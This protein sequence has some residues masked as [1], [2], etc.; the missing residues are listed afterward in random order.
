MYLKK[1]LSLLPRQWTE[2]VVFAELQEDP[3]GDEAS[4]ILVLLALVLDQL[5][6]DAGGR[7]GR[8][9]GCA[10]SPG[11]GRGADGPR[12]LLHHRRH[13]GAKRLRSDGGLQVRR[14]RKGPGSGLKCCIV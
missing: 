1:K 4:V 12:R 2:L 8:A 10:V 5:S 14:R 13:H 3:G 9:V 11:L 7:R 6:G